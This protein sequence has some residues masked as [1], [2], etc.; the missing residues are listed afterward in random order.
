MAA[1][2]FDDLI[3][4]KDL[5][6]PVAAPVKKPEP[7]VTEPTDDV[8]RFENLTRDQLLKAQD[9]LEKYDINRKGLLLRPDAPELFNKQPYEKR[10]TF[11]TSLAEM[12]GETPEVKPVQERVV[13]PAKA[14]EAKRVAP[15]A[16]P[17]TAAAG[18]TFD[19]LVPEEPKKKE[20]KVTAFKDLS[21]PE[22]LK[23]IEEF[24]VA[25]YGESGKRRKNESEED[26][27][28]RWAFAMR[29][30]GLNTINATQELN[31][32]FN[33]PKADVLKAS[34]AYELWDS[35]PSWWEE[36]GQ[37]GVRP[38][39]ESLAAAGADVGTL[40]GFGVG[41]AARYKAARVGFDMALKSRLKA[42]GVGASVEG[43]IGVAESA[44]SQNVE[45]ELKKTSQRDRVERL[46]EKNK[47]LL[48]EN[49]LTEEEFRANEEEFDEYAKEIESQTISVP[50]AVFAGTLSAVAGVFDAGVLARK[51]KLVSTKQELE[52]ILSSRRLLTKEGAKTDVDIAEESLVK[53][54]TDEQEDI[55]ARVAEGR[56]ILNDLSLPTDVT[57]AAVKSDFE[58][59][60]V[61]VA[62]YI[63]LNDPAYAVYKK[64][65][66]S[67]QRKIG[68]V[69][70][71]ILDDVDQID[72][73]VLEAAL[74]KAGINPSEFARAN[75]TTLADAGKIMQSYSTLSKMV[76]KAVEIDPKAEKLLKDFAKAGE[77]EK[78]MGPIRSAILRMER[79]SKAFVV[80]APGVLMRNVMGTSIGMTYQSAS[81]L[82]E[83]AL[84][85]IGKPVRGLL[86]GDVSRGQLEKSMGDFV[87]DAMAP[88]I[89]LTNQGVTSEIVDEVL[90]YN[91]KVQEQL[92]SAL[93]ES[94]NDK[95]T[96][97]ARFVNKGNLA[98]DVLFRR[99]L[100]TASMERQL[101]DVG[102][103]MFD[104]LAKNQVIPADVVKNAADDALRGTFSFMEKKGNTNLI[105]RALERTPF[106]SLIIPFP[107]FMA[108]A[109][110]FQVKYMPVFSGYKA[111]DES[112]RAVGA[113]MKKDPQ[114][115][116]AMYRKAMQ[117][118]ADTAIG[119]IAL[120]AAYN[121]RA[122]N[123]DIKWYE[124]KSTDINPA[125]ILDKEAKVFQPTDAI[126]DTRAIFPL[127][128]YLWL[129]DFM[130]Q[131]F[132]EG[133]TDTSKTKMKEGFETIVGFKAP[134]GT[135]A[136]LL[137][138]FPEL[139]EALGGIFNDPDFES[140]EVKK[141]REEAGKLVGSFLTR[142]INPISPIND[143]LSLFRKESMVARDPNIIDE[144]NKF[145]DAVENQFYSK[146]VGLKEEL[147]ATKPRLREEPIVR[148]GGFLSQLIGIRFQPGKNRLE[149]EL[150]TLGLEDYKLFSPSGDKTFD[151]AVIDAAIPEVINYIPTVLDSED[152][153]AMSRA[154]R[155][156][157][158][159]NTFSRIVSQART[160]AEATMLSSQDQKERVKVFKN[161]WERLPQDK[162]KLINELHRD[163]YGMSLDKAL[164]EDPD[165]WTRVLEYTAIIKQYQR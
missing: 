16:A 130:Y 49:S 94:G 80:G 4:S 165:A 156:E 108:N 31:W 97:L 71:K 146:I 70:M 149:K 36:G 30:A 3:D 6:A 10:K 128:P 100:F 145:T 111:L 90:K 131:L 55:V 113:A 18:I 47:K 72:D 62:E 162:R 159:K 139:V 85:T 25:R 103:N 160:Q 32:V 77:V 138:G 151:R 65:V 140:K 158:L 105:V 41:A 54:F 104:I 28:K 125:A 123:Q 79:E 68:D 66:Y 118:Y 99:A 15:T 126:V 157:T 132:G 164:S 53:A 75:R 91:P 43:T 45:L 21:K 144:D 153:Q 129:G 46:R 109:M 44:I 102:L 61:K 96:W 152:Y 86:T 13:A 127:A 98:Q 8:Y 81:R 2:S 120:L 122:E 92:F 114:R 155:K 12:Q 78:T 57:E 147:P 48:A 5:T 37:S 22:N 154:E 84:Y 34:K 35:V 51:G 59:R 101:R 117:S 82:L 95:L 26:Y 17:T 20:E 64:E 67:K 110:A 134:A 33:A 29:L 143:F 121:Y 119:T 116:E 1:L 161:Q 150:E 52:D 56:T 69:V 93:Q 106:A 27:I 42:A 9:I 7:T 50:Q 124:A 141:V 142:F 39:F 135:T 60:A 107:R 24:A 23:V 63:L 76:K 112:V 73:V 87:K 74:T 40:A 148:A 11:F 14:P 137:E 38:F 133:D 19:D 88:W 89:Y 115:A 58:R 83:G 136:V 163:K